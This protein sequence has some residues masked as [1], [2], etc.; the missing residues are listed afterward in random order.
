MG[1]LS[2]EARE[3]LALMARG[4]TTVEVAAH[5]GTT[6]D[7]VR[8]HLADALTVLGAYSKLEAVIIALRRGLITLALP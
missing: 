1:E 8:R 2:S 7:A 4:L 5:Q 3:I 6:P